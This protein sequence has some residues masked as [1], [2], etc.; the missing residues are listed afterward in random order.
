MDMCGRVYAQ[1][2]VFLTSALDRGVGL[3]SRPGHY[4]IME[5]ALGTH[6]IEAGWA[7]ESDC[8]RYRRENPCPCRRYDAGCL[9]HSLVTTLT[10]L[11]SSVLTMYENYR[12]YKNSLSSPMNY[13]QVNILC[14]KLCTGFSCA[15][16]Y[17]P[18]NSMEQ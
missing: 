18:D 12:N 14:G 3:A 6:W 9:S 16:A 7:S 11:P 1:T 5:R 13:V 10:E 17:V 4:T 8:T 2:G 15:S